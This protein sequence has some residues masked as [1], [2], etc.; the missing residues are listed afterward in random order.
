[1]VYSLDEN[2]GKLMYKLDELDVVDYIVV[3]FILDNG[4]FINEWD[5]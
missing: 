2:I 4:G 5:G 1:M 3:I